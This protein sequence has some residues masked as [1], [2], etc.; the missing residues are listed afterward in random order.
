MPDEILI[1]PAYLDSSKT[2]S[3]G[4]RV[5]KQSAIDKPSTRE[6]ASA[7]QQIGYE[8]VIEK[9]KQYPRSWWEK[10]GRVRVIQPEDSKPDILL[11]VTAYIDAMRN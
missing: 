9:D 1:Y 5:P 6:I 10:K 2:R 3:E 8:A 7:V 4:R 11:A